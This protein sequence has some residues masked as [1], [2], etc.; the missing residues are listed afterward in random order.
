MEATTKQKCADSRLELL[1]TH[2]RR[3]HAKKTLHNINHHDQLKKI[4]SSSSSS[5]SSSSQMDEDSE[6]NKAAME[7]VYGYDVIVLDSS[8]IKAISHKKL[9]ANGAYDNNDLRKE[10]SCIN[11]ILSFDDMV[12]FLSNDQSIDE[13]FKESWNDFNMY[14]NDSN[15]SFNL[16]KGV[17]Y[18]SKSSKNDFNCLCDSIYRINKRSR[19][20]GKT[21]EAYASVVVQYDSESPTT[22]TAA[23]DGD[24]DSDSSEKVLSSS[25]PAQI[26]AMFCRKNKMTKSE[27]VFFLVCWLQPINNTKTDWLPF[28]QYQYEF[29]NV[30]G[31]KLNLSLVRSV[32]V[33]DPFFLINLSNQSVTTSI[34]T[35]RKTTSSSSS[36][37]VINRRIKNSDCRFYGLF[38][39]YCC[40]DKDLSF[41]SYFSSIESLHAKMPQSEST[42]QN[43]TSS[44]SSN[45][46]IQKDNLLNVLPLVFNQQQ[47]LVIEHFIEDEFRI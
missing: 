21:I 43:A 40:R 44:T 10:S 24:S 6:T 25:A 18:T 39:S 9:S 3:E 16:A 42:I 8:E 22:T 30:T 26:C 37:S 2:R 1:C 7:H 15:W 34:G 32:S 14:G 12:S 13:A 47:K 28:Q 31:T 29:A 19:S 20:G 5:S 23:A 4:G 35:K 41:P 33:I 46:Q 38:Q 27:D 11:K 17:N 45:F 36:S